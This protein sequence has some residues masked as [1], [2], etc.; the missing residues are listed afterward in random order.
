MVAN[1][2]AGRCDSPV[3]KWVLAIPCLKLYSLDLHKPALQDLAGK[4]FVAQRHIVK[5]GD[6]K[7]TLSLLSPDLPDVVLM[8][9]LL[10]HLTKEDGIALLQKLQ[11]VAK[12]ILVWLPLGIC[13]QEEYD[14]NVFQRHLSTWTAEELESLGFEVEVYENFH[15]HFAP[16]VD[17]AWA[18]WNS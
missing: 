11:S 17:A 2:G 1:L 3:S 14:G 13:E 18:S 10:E 15:L 16:P 4:V 6:V 8:I 9:D 5:M 7:E 12:R